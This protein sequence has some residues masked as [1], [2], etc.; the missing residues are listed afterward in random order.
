[1]TI[2]LSNSDI[3]DAI[4]PVGAIFITS[5]KVD[6][7]PLQ[8]LGYG[9]WKKIS[10]GRV[11]Q[12]ADTTSKAGSTVEAGLPNITGSWRTKKGLE[13]V[14]SWLSDSTGALNMENVTS[15]TYGG[16]GNNGHG[17][18]GTLTFN[19]SKSNSIYGKSSSVQP[20]AYLVNIFERIS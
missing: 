7:C 5:Q 9:T 2:R 10:V 8:T 19:A 17:N 12:G 13:L 3:I 4:Y 18:A 15:V 20:P 6:I 16:H 14:G 1:M 11:L